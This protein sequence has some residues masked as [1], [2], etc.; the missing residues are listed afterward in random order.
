M[1]FIAF[2]PT[3]I[4]SSTLMQVRRHVGDTEE[5]AVTALGLAF[6]GWFSK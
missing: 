5:N 3:L 2:D 4:A 1:S 6:A